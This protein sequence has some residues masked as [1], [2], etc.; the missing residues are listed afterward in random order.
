MHTKVVKKIASTSLLL[1][2]LCLCLVGCGKHPTNL[3]KYKL[4]VGAL[5]LNLNE[6]SRL[7]MLENDIVLAQDVEWNS[8]NSNVVEVDNGVIRAVGVG[9]S[10]V[11]ATYRGNVVGININVKEKKTG[12]S[13]KKL[14]MIAGEK[15]RLEFIDEDEVEESELT[16]N[17]GNSTIAMVNKGIISGI[18][19]GRTVV[20]ARYRDTDYI[21][22]VTVLD[23][24]ELAGTYRS[25]VYI[26]QMSQTFVFELVVKTDGSYM[27]K[28][29]ANSSFPEEEIARGKARRENEFVIFEN[30][31]SGMKFTISDKDTLAS[32]GAIPTN[33]INIPM[34]FKRK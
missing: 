7:E 32:V 14:T 28:R 15:T 9:T 33:R 10:L 6:E 16:W 30:K 3:Y 11:T 12:I 18:N 8:S 4:N 29:L 2:C 25:E 17:T 13:K 21:C 5:N 19:A 23:K 34:T 31:K 20:V 27:Y 24:F 22:E 26:S 1:L